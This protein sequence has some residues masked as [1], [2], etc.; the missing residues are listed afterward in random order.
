MKKLYHIKVY[1]F[2]IKE[3]NVSVF[4]PL[5]ASCEK[6]LKIKGA[7]LYWIIWPKISLN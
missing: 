4:C 1:D 5:I 6:K 3:L 2:F 7:K